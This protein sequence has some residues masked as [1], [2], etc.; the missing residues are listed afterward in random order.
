V[1]VTGTRH[2][3]LQGTLSDLPPPSAPALAH[4]E[5]LAE[6]I[7]QEIRAAGGSIPFSR[8]MELCLYSPGLGYYSAGAEKFGAAGDFVTAPEISTLFGRSLARTCGDVLEQLGNGE[9]LE[10][11]AGTGSLAATL[12]PELERLG[13]LPGR[14]CIL[15]R[16]ADL[17]ARQEETLQRLP[18]ALR[19]RV[20]WLDAFPEGAFRG[21]ML[22]NEV[23]DAMPVERFRW[24]GAG[25]ERCHVECRDGG[26]G[27]CARE[28]HAPDL[29]A[30]VRRLAGDP[31]LE[32]GYVSEIN[33]LLAPWLREIAARL[34][35]GLLLLIDY[36]Y[37]R[38]EY[39]HPQRR[40]GTLI[41]HYRHR[42]HDDPFLWPGLQ[43][44]TAHVDFTAVAEAGAAAGL[45]VLGYSTQ[46]WF[47]LDCG[48][49]ELLGAAGPTDSAAYLR[50]AQEAK[51]LML[52]GGMGERFKCIGLGRGIEEAVTG[53]RGRDLRFRL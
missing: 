24:T 11:G 44:I 29:V 28:A 27:W 18:A 7:R 13:R 36:G 5:R 12:L 2:E 3:F 33:L 48:L 50:L 53:F 45:E 32:P 34:E 8:Y 22:A 26:F 14:Y 46:A 39:Y 49:Q 51:T 6:R 16:S 30:A 37:P 40:E 25:V 21:M 41:C 9:V 4:S 17:R 35:R 31:G 38:R 10:F 20:E 15:D 47:L 52:P 42:A 1:A 43:D 23:L 19:E